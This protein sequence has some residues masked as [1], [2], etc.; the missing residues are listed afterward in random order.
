MSS[1]V[2][3]PGHSS[4]SSEPSEPLED[5]TTPN[6]SS[7]V[8]A[9]PDA[10]GILVEVDASDLDENDEDDDGEQVPTAEE[11][12]KTLEA[13]AQ[14]SYER[15]LRTTADFENFRKRA[16]RDVA[17]ARVDEQSRVLREMLPVV[18]N[19]ERA[20]AAA[21]SDNEEVKSIRQGVELVLRQF[22]QALER[23]SVVR[24]EA[25]GASFDPN[26][27]E[28]VSQLETADHLPGTIVSV[29]QSGYTIGDRLL[30]AALTVVAKA[31]STPAPPTDATAP[32]VEDDTISEESQSSAMTDQT[33][34][35]ESD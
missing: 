13:N 8:D 29:L 3:Q 32:A 5:G 1:H 24:I 14:E 33:E 35:E 9:A 16:R 28:A 15:L 20:V 18:D 34:D 31:P 17:D 27:H 4:E 11:Q 21:S 10:E 2:E 7:S 19:L 22:S 23:F 25:E 12:I 6:G 30:R 26:I